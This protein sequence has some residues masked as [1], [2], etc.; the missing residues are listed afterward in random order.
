MA[1]TVTK[2]S[3]TI[4]NNDWITTLNT[5]CRIVTQDEAGSRED[6]E[7]AKIESNSSTS[8]TKSDLRSLWKKT[9]DAKNFD[10]YTKARI[11]L[12][13]ATDKFNSE[14]SKE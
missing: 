11:D 2:V 12:I 4:S 1:F 3:H 13:K 14:K 8:T 9:T 5:V 7:K 6:L 10:D